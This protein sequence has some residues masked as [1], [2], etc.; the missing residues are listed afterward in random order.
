[1]LQ[2]APVLVRSLPVHLISAPASLLPVVVCM[3]SCFSSLSHDDRD[4]GFR[5]PCLLF[6]SDP[7]IPGQAIKNVPECSGGSGCAVP[8]SSSW[9]PAL[10]PCTYAVRSSLNSLSAAHEIPAYWSSA[11]PRRYGLSCASL[12]PPK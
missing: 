4:T 10:N 11:G 7:L 2:P 9:K 12:C 5:Y 1:M 3:P 6:L 8:S